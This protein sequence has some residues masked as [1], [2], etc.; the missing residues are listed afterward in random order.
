MAQAETDLP[1]GRS[2]AFG[3]W[4]GKIPRRTQWQPSPGYAWEIPWTEGWRATVPDE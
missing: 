1:A 4:V 3:P 2:S